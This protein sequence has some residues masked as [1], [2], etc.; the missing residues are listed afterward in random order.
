MGAYL[1]AKAKM[2]EVISSTSVREGAYIAYTSAPRV[3]R[4]SMSTSPVTVAL[5]AVFVP[6]I[7]VIFDMDGTLTE[8][9]AIDFSEMYRRTGFVA[10]TGDLVSMVNAV[11]DNTRRQELEVITYHP[12]K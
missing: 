7:G 11:T 12:P 3:T 6:T 9:G 5:P 1:A 10:G 2:D 4:T 8:P